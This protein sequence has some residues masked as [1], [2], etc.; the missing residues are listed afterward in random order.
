MGNLKSLFSITIFTF[1]LLFSF[2]N[3]SESTKRDIYLVLDM[4]G[5]LHPQEA[6]IELPLKE[7]QTEKVFSFAEYCKEEF[8]SVFLVYPY[9]NIEKEDFVNLG[10]S[11]VLRR[12]CDNNT[13]FDSFSTLLFIRKGVVVSYSII[14]AV[15][16]WF[17]P[18]EVEDYYIFSIKQKF[19]MD[20]DRNIHI[21]NK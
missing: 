19:I 2:T 4:A 7:Q 12:K 10:M 21:Y 1:V 8:D 16:A 15:D 11:N 17:E 5:L 20:K 18:R 6:I 9:F 14:D 13:N 3:C